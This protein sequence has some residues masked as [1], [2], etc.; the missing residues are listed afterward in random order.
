M[1]Q[2]PY[3]KASKQIQAR[4]NRRLIFR[5]HAALFTI[6]I[7]AFFFWLRGQ[8]IGYPVLLIPPAAWALLLVG[9]W[10]YKGFA[11]SRDAAVDRVVEQLYGEKMDG[12]S[13]SI[14]EMETAHP[15][16]DD[17]RHKVEIEMAREKAKR[18]RLLFRINIAVYLTV[19]LLGWIIIPAVYGPFLTESSAL[20]IFALTF[21]GLGQLVLHYTAV[22]LDTLE[23]EQALRERLL[24]RALQQSMAQDGTQKTK[25]TMRLTEDGELLD[26]VDEHGATKRCD[27]TARIACGCQKLVKGSIKSA[28]TY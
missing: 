3:Q 4:R 17:L 7:V 14:L 23:G 10:F 6:A 2:L 11:D 16:F 24:G 1:S 18:R 20:T 26:I 13:P 22:R 28:A 25:R 15:N 9:H 21:A 5:L 19:M 8:I 12:M 27:N